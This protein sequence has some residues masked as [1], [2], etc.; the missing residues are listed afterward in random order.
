MNSLK[1][2]L[3]SCLDK[4]I[5]TITR[6]VRC[7]LRITRPSRFQSRKAGFWPQLF[8]ALQGPRVFSWGHQSPIHGPHIQLRWEVPSRPWKQTL[9][10]EGRGFQGPG[11]WSVL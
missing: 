6:T 2:I 7:G 5:F 10:C 11:P 3:S 9:N 1:S 8:P 4:H